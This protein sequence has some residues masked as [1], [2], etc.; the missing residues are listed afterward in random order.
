M[1]IFANTYHLQKPD[2]GYVGVIFIEKRLLTFFLG[3][4]K[5]GKFQ[6]ESGMK[7]QQMPYGVFMHT[8]GAISVIAIDNSQYYGL[9]YTYR[10]EASVL[11]VLLQWAFQSLEKQ[12]E[13]LVRALTLFLYGGYLD[14]TGDKIIP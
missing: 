4:S 13:Q 9:L 7:Q 11:L 2:M 5:S 10:R 12:N 6:L 3:F 14:K 8:D 1:L